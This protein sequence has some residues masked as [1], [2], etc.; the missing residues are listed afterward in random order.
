MLHACHKWIV[1]KITPIA[2]VRISAHIFAKGV[3]YCWITFRIVTAFWWR[4]CILTISSMYTYNE[5]TIKIKSWKAYWSTS[6]IY[7][8]GVET[9]AMGCGFRLTTNLCCT[10]EFTIWGIGCVGWGCGTI[11]CIWVSAIFIRSCCAISANCII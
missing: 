6:I 1:N 2:R 9:I 11:C 4:T 5:R 10:E 8:G 3:T 7:N